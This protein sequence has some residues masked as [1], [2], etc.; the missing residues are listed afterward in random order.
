MST[1]KLKSLDQKLAKFSPQSRKRIDAG[2]K[3]I[4]QEL[5]LLKKMREL[6]GISQEQLAERLDVGQSYISKLEGRENIT[7]L[8]LSDV[9]KALGG[10]VELTIRLPNKEPVI[11]PELETY[12]R[13]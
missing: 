1:K 5:D 10:S 6:M 2:A 7:L 9:A 4:R 3:R 13:D 8:T 12:F 11:V